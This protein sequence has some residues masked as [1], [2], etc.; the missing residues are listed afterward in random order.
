MGLHEKI[1]IGGSTP[2]KIDTKSVQSAIDM[3]EP[4]DVDKP[5][6]VYIEEEDD[7]GAVFKQ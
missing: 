6:I 7:Y 2:P 3:P 4:T 5:T 1:Q